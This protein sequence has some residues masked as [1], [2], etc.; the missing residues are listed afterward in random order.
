MKLRQR[1]K[2]INCKKVV[3][4]GFLLAIFYIGSATLPSTAK[5]IAGFFKG[6]QNGILALAANIDD[7]YRNMLGFS[8]YNLRNKGFYINLNG[9]M[10]RTMGQRYMNERIKLDNGH[11]T[12]LGGKRDTTLAAVQLKKLH[13]KQAENGKSFLFVLAPYQIP[14]YEV[15]IPAGYEDYRNQN[16]DNLLVVL[17]E[18]G[19]PV[20]DLREEMYIDGIGHS[21]AFFV[22]DH[23]WKPETGFWAYMK[24]IQTLE[25]ATM[26][27]PID[28]FYTDITEYNIEVYDEFCLGSH[29]KRTGRYYA[30]IDDIEIITPGFDSDISI[31]I[32]SK[33]LNIRGEL[34]ETAFNWDRLEKDFF[35]ANPYATYN[36]G[37]S[38]LKEY[39]NE[40]APADLKVL[41]IGD[42]FALVPFTFLPLVFSACNQ[43]DMRL[44]EGDFLEYYSGFDPDIIIVLVNP[45]Q[46][47]GDNT[48]YD[49][50]NDYGEN[51]DMAKQGDDDADE[52]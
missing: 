15:I 6:E 33:E 30:G 22:T 45:S 44:F 25:N 34:S 7:Q 1:I 29:G 31:S 20:L 12:Y 5:S 16:A 48:T 35:S 41:T 3:A 21:E 40:S 8:D 24:I 47:A 37:R 42:S 46:V 23:H 49:F 10:A 14:K 36:H 4:A 26:I 9:L 17:K 39:R 50:F 11:L 28:S 52:R 38:D 27:D 2:R 43:L 32:P 19:I 18:E 13:D 51:E